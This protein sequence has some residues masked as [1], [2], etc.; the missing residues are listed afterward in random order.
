MTGLDKHTSGRS[1]TASKQQLS[2]WGLPQPILEAFR[3]KGLKQL[4]PWQAA[5]LDCAAAG[6][7]L[8]YCAPTSG[9]AWGPSI[10]ALCSLDVKQSYWFAGSTITCCS[11]EFHSAAVVCLQPGCKTIAL[12]HQACA[13][14]TVCIPAHSQHCCSTHNHVLQV[15][16]ASWQMCC[17]SR[18]CTRSSK[19]C[20]AGPGPRRGAHLSSSSSS[21]SQGPSSSCLTSALV[22]LRPA[23]ASTTCSSQIQAGKCCRRNW[24][25]SMQVHAR[26][27]FIPAA[28][29]P[30][31]EPTWCHILIR[32]NA[33]PMR[34][35][36]CCPVLSC[37][38]SV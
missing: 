10:Q 5:A 18:A 3:K 17:C 21:P 34:A 35:V 13:I 20:W 23:S 9:A 26:C 32:H 11:K 12:G 1:S 16:R 2:A 15:A 28:V 27:S 24:R 7:N 19:H 8:V 36:L 6:N 14:P 29:V 38:A 33:W 37:V 4:Y 25:A 30:Q 31:S 22:R